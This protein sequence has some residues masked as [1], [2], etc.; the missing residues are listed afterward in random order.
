MGCGCEVWR[1]WGRFGVL[2]G[3]CVGFVAYLWIWG[4]SVGRAFV[5]V[6]GVVFGLSFV[7]GACIWWVVV[8]GGWGL[9]FVL[10][11]RGFGGGWVLERGFGA[12]GFGVVRVFVVGACLVV[13]IVV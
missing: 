4:F 8:V 11:C 6:L 5:C 1:V 3:F 7:V 13:F 2:C 12:W 10:H 9:L